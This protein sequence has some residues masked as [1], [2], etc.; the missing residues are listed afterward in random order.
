[1]QSKE[2]MRIR[3]QGREIQNI[4]CVIGGVVPGN[5]LSFSNF[6]PKSPLLGV[7]IDSQL[8]YGTP[9]TY[10][11]STVIYDPVSDR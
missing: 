7:Q 10:T 8:S 2:S 9:T 5:L 4:S 6:D 1:M 3:L 11:Q